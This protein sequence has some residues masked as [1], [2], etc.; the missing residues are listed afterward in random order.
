MEIE[1]KLNIDYLTYKTG[2]KKKDK[3]MILKKLKQKDLLEKKFITM[4]YH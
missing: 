4:I 1:N 3:N 2:N